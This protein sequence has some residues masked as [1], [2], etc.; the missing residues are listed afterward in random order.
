M[1]DRCL[2]SCVPVAG[3]LPLLLEAKEGAVYMCAALFSCVWKHGEQC[4]RAD[5]CP[6][7]S[8]P[9]RGHRGASCARTGAASR[10]AV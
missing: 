3:G 4:H 10:V 6:S 5:D 7:E 1:G 2:S 9:S 8:S